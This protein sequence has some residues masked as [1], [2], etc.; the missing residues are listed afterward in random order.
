M[1]VNETVLSAVV[2]IISDDLAIGIYTGDNRPLFARIGIGNVGETAIEKDE[3][4]LGALAVGVIAND[5]TCPIDRSRDRAS[6]AR[7]RV[8]EICVR[9]KA[10]HVAWPPADANVL[11]S[12]NSPGPQPPNNGSAWLAALEVGPYSPRRRL[13]L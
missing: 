6:A 10:R 2:V 1:A 11:V 13:L 9:R 3:A 7:V 4:V 12:E 5:F 8:T